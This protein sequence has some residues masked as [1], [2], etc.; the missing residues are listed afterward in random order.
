[1][2]IEVLEYAAFMAKQDRGDYDIT[3]SGW[4]N[5][6]PDPE[7]ALTRLF[8]TRGLGATNVAFY[9]NPTFDELLN[10]GAAASEGE[11]RAAV[12][13]EVQKFF[14]N[15]AP[16]LYWSVNDIAVGFGPRV[17]EFP[18]HIRGIYKLN[19]VVRAD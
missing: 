11:E 16:A 12:Y 15:E 4:G 7:F 6:L 17:K 13:K 3:L 14:I 5:N 19:K 2:N 8:H 9:S 18:A 10:K 1:V